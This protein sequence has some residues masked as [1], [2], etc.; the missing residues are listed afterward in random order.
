MNV[1]VIRSHTQTEKC[2]KKLDLHHDEVSALA[3]VGPSLYTGS[4]DCTVRHW[5]IVEELGA[6]ER[7]K[8]KTD[9]PLP[10]VADSVKKQE[11]TADEERE[12]AELMDDED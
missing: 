9:S 5:N 12:L 10:S 4:Y 8:R 11:L 3:V 1:H 2:L 6:G 7:P